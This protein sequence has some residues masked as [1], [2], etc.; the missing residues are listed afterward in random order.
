[1]LIAR[2]RNDVE[3]VFIEE[4]SAVVGLLMF[5]DEVPSTATMTVA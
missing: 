2:C 4:V 1:M 5:T 3:E